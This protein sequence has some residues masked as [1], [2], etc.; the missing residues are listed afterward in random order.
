M[1]HI[2]EDVTRC[3]LASRSGVLTLDFDKEKRHTNSSDTKSSVAKL[4]THPKISCPP[5]RVFTVSSVRING[6]ASARSIS[7]AGACEEKC[8]NVAMKVV[9][10]TGGTCTEVDRS[11]EI[12]AES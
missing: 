8:F 9:G 5:S 4:P 11:L 1:S 7:R 3:P 10:S 12:G 2:V 6:R